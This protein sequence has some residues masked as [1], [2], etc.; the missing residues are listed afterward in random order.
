MVERSHMSTKII[1]V[2]RQQ[3]RDLTIEIS[4]GVIIRTHG[5][6]HNITLFEVMTY[7]IRLVWNPPL[8]TSVPDERIGYWGQIRTFSVLSRIFISFEIDPN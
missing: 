8:P 5:R 3:G 7:A 4:Y 6:P 2:L 1:W